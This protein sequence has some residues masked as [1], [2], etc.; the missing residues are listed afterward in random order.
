MVNIKHL[1]IINK[2]IFD[3]KILIIFFYGFVLFLIIY[4]KSKNKCFCYLFINT[5]FIDFDKKKI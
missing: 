1:D 3:F 4:K 5:I 2:L